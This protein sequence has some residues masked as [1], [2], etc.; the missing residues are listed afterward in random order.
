[1]GKRREIRELALQTLYQLDARDGADLEQIEQS[2]RE[3]PQGE[4]SWTLAQE[5]W[6]DRERADALTTELAPKWPPNRQPVVDRC[7]L[8]LAHHELATGRAAPAVVIDEAVE[9]AKRYGSER[10]PA[11][12]NGV[13]DR[14]A[15]RLQD[16]AAG[17]PEP[18][19]SEGSE[20]ETDSAKRE[21]AGAEKGGS[22]D[23]WLDEALRQARP[24]R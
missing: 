19:G 8:R 18:P 11:F 3:S 17:S 7:I 12:I 5:A 9:L 24:T 16:A 4:A 14:M 22:N 15:R 10:S 23:P 2:T 1:M 21:D 6:A 13:L 20:S